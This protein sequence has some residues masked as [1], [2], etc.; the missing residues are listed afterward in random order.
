[1]QE[2]LKFKCRMQGVKGKGFR[3]YLVFKWWIFVERRSFWSYLSVWL[4]GFFSRVLI[5]WI[6]GSCDTG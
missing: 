5:G 6:E 4:A 3:V 1:M 2:Y